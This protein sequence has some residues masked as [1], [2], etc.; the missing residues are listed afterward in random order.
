MDRLAIDAG[1]SV[2]NPADLLADPEASLQADLVAARQVFEKEMD[3][4]KALSEALDAS[5][6]QAVD[7]LLRLPGKVIVTGMG[8]S[9]HIGRKLAATLASTGTPAFFVHPG[10]AS[11]GDLGMIGPD[12]GVIALSNS[13][14]TPELS[15]LIAFTRR[16]N[17]L[18]VSIT[19][20]R[21]NTLAEAADVSL[22]LPSAPEACPHG[23]APTTSTVMTMALGDALAVALLERRGFSAADFKTFHPGGQLGRNL[24]RCSDLM[25]KGAGLPLVD[26]DTP[27]GAVVIEIT[28]KSLGCAGVVDAEGILVGIITDG[29]LR[30]HM[31]DSLLDRTAADVMTGNPTQVVPAMLAVEALG[32]M[33]RKTITSVFIV[34]GESRPVGVL[35][36]HDCLRAGLA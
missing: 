22:I 18:L 9:G 6:S 3:G 7:R 14:E 19:G 32:V 13:G 28:A 30:R 15:D 5:F 21:G 31:E 27:M 12:D 16:F 11:H 10:E 23:L 1:S 20:R 4:L 25:H 36:L 33:N 29:D 2:P 34:D 8:K 17:I 35:H 24:L 26:L